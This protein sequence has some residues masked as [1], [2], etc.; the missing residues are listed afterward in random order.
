MDAAPL[1]RLDLADLARNLGNNQ[2]VLQKI[3]RVFMRAGQNTLFQ[4][5][6][7]ERTRNVILW[8]QLLHQLKGAALSVTAR[9]LA[10]LCSEAEGIQRLPHDQSEA[11]LFHL[12][13]EM[14]CLRSDMNRY[15]SEHQG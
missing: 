1:S 9:R 10:S 5:E 8:S 6:E 12:H 7:A 14:A 2:A 3:V 15:L 13:K 4:L 11:M